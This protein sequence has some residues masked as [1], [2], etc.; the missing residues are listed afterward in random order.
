MKKKMLLLS[1]GMA[2]LVGCS[3]AAWAASTTTESSSAS[4]GSTGGNSAV[5]AALK[6]CAASVAKDSNG[7][8]DETAMTAC[9]TKAGFTKPAQDG[10][11][12]PPPGS[13]SR[14]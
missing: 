11:R 2:C 4:T 9:M 1:L 12:P 14:K 5:D 7:G 3:A 10:G 8:P 13:A 6:T